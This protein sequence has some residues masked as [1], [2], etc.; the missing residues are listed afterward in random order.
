[1]DLTGNYFQVFDLPESFEIDQQ[2]LKH[3]YQQLQRQCHPDKYAGKSS[4]QQRLAEQ[5][6]VFLNQAY[7]TLESPMLRAEYLLSLQGVESNLANTTHRDSEFL[8]E[9]MELQEALEEVRQSANQHQL[10][11]G[12]VAD[13]DDRFQ[14]LQD[15]FAEEFKKGAYNEALGT[16]AK[17]HFFNKLQKQADRLE[18]EW[19]LL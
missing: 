2:K 16:L 15:K 6:T 14:A 12:L 7:T 8:M 5:Y 10:L 4:Q 3:Q 13:I 18:E 9:Q 19:E 11:E 1:M 17:M